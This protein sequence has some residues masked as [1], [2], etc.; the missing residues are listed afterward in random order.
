MI[1]LLL[2]AIVL[3]GFASQAVAGPLHNAARDG[4]VE[5]VKS[6]IASGEDVNKRDRNLGWPLHQAAISN[7]I[8]IAELL[9]AEGADV[10]AE[11][12]FLGTPLYAAALK[13]SVE[14]AAIL[15]ANGANPN[16]ALSTDRLAILKTP[17]HVAAEIG[18]VGFVE[19]LVAND[20][21]VNARSGRPQEERFDFAPIHSAGV[22]GH[23]NIV[24]LLR[25]LGA[26]G[27]VVEPI[28]DLLVNADP[29][30]GEQIFASPQSCANKCHTIGKGVLDHKTGPN[31]WGV[32]G[33]KKAS[34]EGFEYSEA[35]KQLGGTWTVA[36]LNAYI[37]SAVDYLPG[38]TMLNTG[39]PDAGD[40]AD[41]IAFL[42]QNR[43]N[44][45]AAPVSVVN[46]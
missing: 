2:C 18:D 32:V 26:A 21:D 37:A 38:T 17:L 8:D 16:P 15:L 6:L 23:P 13:G 1:R 24:A 45:P 22:G 31:L 30:R 7:D 35:L 42:L 39:M 10:D 41:L 12:R 36:E 25:A 5:Q 34:I 20:A 11:H 43:D 40:R 4:D 9:I 14:V 46:Q 19:L 27:P 29:S 3:G 44:P 33:R 28:S